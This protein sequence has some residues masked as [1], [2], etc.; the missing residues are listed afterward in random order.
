LFAIYVYVS[1]D[2]SSLAACC[3]QTI[4]ERSSPNIIVKMDFVN[5]FDRKRI[6]KN[7]LDLLKIDMVIRKDLCSL[8]RIL[9]NFYHR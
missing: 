5:E 1:T 2:V 8:I 4:V 3:G 7:V 6:V 9:C